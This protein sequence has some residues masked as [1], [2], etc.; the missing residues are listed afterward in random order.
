MLN[1][2]EAKDGMAEIIITAM[3]TG[4]DHLNSIIERLRKIEGITEIL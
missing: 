4:K 1:A 3:I 2:R